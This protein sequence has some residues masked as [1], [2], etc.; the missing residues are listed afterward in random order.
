MTIWLLAIW[1]YGLGVS[2]AYGHRLRDGPGLWPQAFSQC[3]LAI[4]LVPWATC[5]LSYFGS[6]HVAYGH[7]PTESGKLE[8]V[9][10]AR[11]QMGRRTF[12]GNFGRFGDLWPA[13][14]G[15]VRWVLLRMVP[16]T[17]LRCLT[18]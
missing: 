14:R 2:E 13:C 16:M 10:H 12:G 18:R 17:D 3:P 4:W 8:Q 15:T 5:L 11:R 1:L 7:L 6:G 9:Q